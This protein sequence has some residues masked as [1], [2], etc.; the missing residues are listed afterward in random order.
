MNANIAIDIASKELKVS[1]IIQ[2]NYLFQLL[3][4]IR[5]YRTASVHRMLMVRN[6]NNDVTMNLL[7]KK[8][9]PAD[10]NQVEY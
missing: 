9:N 4:T 7:V 3:R 1:Q 10:M 5:E 8:R 2:V 6:V